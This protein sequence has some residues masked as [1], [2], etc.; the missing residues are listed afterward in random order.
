M[1]GEA[2]E[3]AVVVAQGVGHAV[4]L[5]VALRGPGTETGVSNIHE[6]SSRS[7]L[8]EIGEH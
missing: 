4:A 6:A 3:L 7:L 1:G 8:E 5:V 2:A